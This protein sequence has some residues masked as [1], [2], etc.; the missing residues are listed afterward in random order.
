M[1]E[2]VFKTGF[3]MGRFCGS[4]AGIESKTDK[5]GLFKQVATFMT[6]K[7]KKYRF[8]VLG[9]LSGDF[10]SVAPFAVIEVDLINVEIG[11]S[12]EFGNYGDQN[13]TV[14]SMKLVNS[15]VAAID[16]SKT[17]PIPERKAA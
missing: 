9:A 16:R 12:G 2:Q 5:N 17:V 10:E 3:L 11:K 1:S 7:G 6:T 15:N 4:F 8:T 13:F 14:D